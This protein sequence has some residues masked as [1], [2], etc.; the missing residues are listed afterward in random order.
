MNVTF[1]YHQGT[2]DNAKDL[3]E[4]TG[5]TCYWHTV[6]KHT[7]RLVSSPQSPISNANVVTILAVHRMRHH[8]QHAWHSCLCNL[9]PLGNIRGLL[10]APVPYRGVQDALQRNVYDC[11]PAS[12]HHIRRSIFHASLHLVL[13]CIPICIHLPGLSIGYQRRVGLRLVVE[14]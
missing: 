9:S 7:R 6:L 13:H 1:L 11:F 4:S 10:L 3:Q 14:Q 12:K 2:P 5:T 8:Y